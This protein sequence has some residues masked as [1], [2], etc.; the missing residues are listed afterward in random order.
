MVEFLKYSLVKKFEEFPFALEFWFQEKELQIEIEFNSD[1]K[2]YKNF[3]KLFFDFKN[4]T[5]S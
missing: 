5:D 4:F 1:Q 2:L 3:D